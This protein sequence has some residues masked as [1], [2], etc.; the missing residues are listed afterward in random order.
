MHEVAYDVNLVTTL[1][2][3]LTIFHIANPCITSAGSY[4]INNSGNCISDLAISPHLPQRGRENYPFTPIP[5]KK[6]SADLLRE[7]LGL[8]GLTAR[9][10]SLNSLTSWL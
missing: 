10:R 6:V 7:A 8:I 9:K 4:Q 5:T 2:R 3:H 1:F